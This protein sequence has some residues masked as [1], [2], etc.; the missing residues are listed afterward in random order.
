MILSRTFAWHSPATRRII[1]S[2]R[3]QH[4]TCS[5]SSVSGMGSLPTIILS[6]PRTS[7]VCLGSKNYLRYSSI[8]QKKHH[9]VARPIRN[10]FMSSRVDEDEA[11][12][13]ETVHS[14]TIESTW[15]V[16]GLKKE[17][18]RLIQRAHKKIGKVSQKLTHA[19]EI[20]ETLRS[21]PDAT[22]EELESCPDIRS[23]EL[24]LIEW[25][26]RL[27]SLNA[28]DASL[29]TIK[30]KNTVLPP[31]IAASAI[32]LGVDDQPPTRPERG[33]PKPKGPRVSEPNRKPYRRYYSYNN[34]EIRVGK[35]AEDNDDLT[36]L[37]EHRDDGDWWMH[38]SGCPGSHVVI[39]C[40]DAAIPD[41]VVLDAAALA[42]RQSKCQGS[43][44]KVSMTRCR[45]IRK[46]PGAK[47]GLVMLVGKVRTVSVDMRQA[48]ARLTRLEETVKIN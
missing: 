13:T 39:R 3:W 28:L 1:T 19:Q 35:K 23:I 37:P 27:Q 5:D 15:F 26:E 43:T 22:L 30:K 42:A 33:P 46:P 29:A 41:E 14:K 25:K 36:M 24:D 10:L 17:V 12:G 45:D 2:R 18:Q 32:S 7:L 48:Q 38:A 6:R 31:D 16:L 8:A 44:V 20:V 4:Q 40:T 47:A 11:T 34:I 21:K 9:Y